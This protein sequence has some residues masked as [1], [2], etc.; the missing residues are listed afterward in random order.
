MAGGFSGFFLVVAAAI[1]GLAVFELMRSFYL[2][3]D[4]AFRGGELVTG[5]IG[6]GGRSGQE[7]IAGIIKGINTAIIAVAA[8]ELGM[9]IGKEYGT[10]E[11]EGNL[12]SLMRRTVTRFVALVCIALVLEALIMVIR[13]A[14]LELA[15]NL[16]YPVAILGGASA[17]LLALGG[18]LALTRGDGAPRPA[19]DP[20]TTAGHD[21][22]EAVL[23]GL[24]EGPRRPRS[25]AASG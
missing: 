1:G 19:G 16:G 5:F 8:F 21:G 13:Y 18:F 14:Q 17:L 4:A 7:L 2:F 23:Q 20:A 25:T 24:P 9:G 6:E 11:S 3:L 10:P 22:P 15:G 12:F